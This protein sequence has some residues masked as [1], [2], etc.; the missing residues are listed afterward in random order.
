MENRS[1]RAGDFG[2]DPIVL[3]ACLS[4][5]G[6][7]QIRSHD[8]GNNRITMVSSMLRWENAEYPVIHFA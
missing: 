7:V 4:G 8:P 3:D 6:E 1:P 5:A 2:K